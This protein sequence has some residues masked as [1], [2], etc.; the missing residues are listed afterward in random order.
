MTAL[1]RLLMGLAGLLLIAFLAL[2]LAVMWMVGQ[3]P[4]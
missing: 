2:C 1:K 3:L 4:H